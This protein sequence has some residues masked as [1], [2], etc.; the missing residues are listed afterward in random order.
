LLKLVAIGASAGGLHAVS[1]ILTGLPQ[2]FPGCLAIVQH[3]RG[4][5]GSLLRE[6][7]AQKSPFPVI[8]PSHG[9]PIRPGHVY[10]APPDYHLLVE[11]GYFALSVDPPISCSR[12]SIDALFESAASAYRRRAIGVVLTGANADGAEGAA[13]LHRL[14][15]TVIVQDPSTA[16]APACPTAALSSVPSA[17][18]LPLSEIPNHLRVLCGAGGS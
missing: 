8:E 9:A 14:G 10:L 6:L 13:Q 7:L 17:I 18:V 15:G 3:R 2:G 11:P 12:P 4:D 1:Q 16:E 5:S